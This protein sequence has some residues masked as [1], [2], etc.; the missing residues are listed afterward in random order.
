MKMLSFNDFFLQKKQIKMKPNVKYRL[1][2]GEIIIFG[3]VRAQFKIYGESSSSSSQSLL[4]PVI[5]SQERE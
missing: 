1:E 3:N 5:N 2:D 4:S